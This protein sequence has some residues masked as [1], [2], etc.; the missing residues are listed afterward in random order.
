MALT[1]SKV[2]RC[3]AVADQTATS[4]RQAILCYVPNLPRCSFHSGNQGAILRRSSSKCYKEARSSPPPECLWGICRRATSYAT[5][6][7]LLV[8]CNLT[9]APQT[10][11]REDI[12]HTSECAD[13]SGEGIEEK[14]VQKLASTTQGL[15]EAYKYAHNDAKFVN[16]R[17]RKDM[18]LLSRGLRR[19]DARA[20]Q[21]VAILGLGF[22]KLDARAREDTEKIDYNVKRKAERLHHIATILK[23]KAESRLKIVADQHWSDGALEADLRRADLRAKRRAM[24]DTLMALEF[25]KNIHDMMVTKMKLTGAWHLHSLKLMEL[26]IRILKRQA[27]ANALAAAPSMWTLGNAGMGALQRLAD[28]SD[29]AVAAAASRAIYELKQQWEIQEGDSWRFTL[30]QNGTEEDNG[31]TS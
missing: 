21:D 14:E 6:R 24:E 8:Q 18:V 27:L 16:E 17:A 30:N 29:P 28:D 22:L 19:L 13:I 7:R 31:A 2:L 1:P 11:S 23:D 4:N 12:R 9:E 15:A 20:R 3:P 26:T 10:K 5:C 25:V